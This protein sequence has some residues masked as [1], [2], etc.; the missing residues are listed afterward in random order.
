M[1]VLL[2][3]A[4]EADSVLALDRLGISSKPGEVRIG[5]ARQRDL[6][7]WPQADRSIAAPDPGSSTAN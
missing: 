3:G 5:L 6:I 4:D 7:G 1:Q 2:A